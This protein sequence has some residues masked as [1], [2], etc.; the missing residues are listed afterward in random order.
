MSQ[1]DFISAVKNV[2]LPAAFCGVCAHCY[3]LG[4]LA[5]CT[6]PKAMQRKSNPFPPS[7][8]NCCVNTVHWG[9]K[10]SDINVRRL[11]SESACHWRE[12]WTYLWNSETVPGQQ[13]QDRATEPGSLTPS[14]APWVGSVKEAINF[15]FFYLKIRVRERERERERPTDRYLPSTNSLPK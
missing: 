2:R 4:L 3:A 12:R 9:V 6:Q 7:G 13:W 15:L 1:K 14:P 8:K 10:S 11:C 5:R